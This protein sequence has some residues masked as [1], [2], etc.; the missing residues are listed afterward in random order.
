MIS[1]VS[2]IPS[3]VWQAD[4]YATRIEYSRAVIEELGIAATDGFNRLAHGGVEIGGV[5]FGVR[6]S[7]SIEI[8]AHRALT[9]EYA[10][11]PSFTLSE[12]DGR[13]LEDLLA[14][15]ADNPEL[16]GMQAVG[17][18]HSHT[19]SDISLSQKDLELYQH[20]FPELWQIALVLRPYRFDPVRAGF[21]FRERDGSVYADATRQEFIIHRP[22]QKP[23]AR[24]EADAEPVDYKPR[25]APA[26]AAP[27]AAATVAL[28]DQAS[29]SPAPE[30]KTNEPAETGGMLGPSI[31]CAGYRARQA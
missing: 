31:K 21:F 29:P 30:P 25:D 5:L 27:V 22:R 7:D 20:Y 18:Y 2:D 1:P 26:A 15:V 16:A 4:G 17:W 10:F 19:R 3:E 28:L 11:G 8:L 14:S 13:A 23:I 12:N 9:C 6:N 24:L